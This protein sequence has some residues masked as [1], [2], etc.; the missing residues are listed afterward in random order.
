VTDEYRATAQVATDAAPRYAKQLAAHLGRRLE[1]RDEDRGTRLVFANGSCLMVASDAALEL[2]V[3]AEDAPGLENVKDV[4]A[5]HLER[6]G[7]RNE[8]TVDWK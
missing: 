6:F 7:Q 1:V 3:E 5:R 4:V 8:L 2:L